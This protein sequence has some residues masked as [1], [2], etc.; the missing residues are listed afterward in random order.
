MA[1]AMAKLCETFGWNRV[2]VVHDNSFW[3]EGAANDFIKVAQSADPSFEAIAISQVNKSDSSGSAMQLV[4]KELVAKGAKIVYLALQRAA[5]REFFTQVFE[6]RDVDD[7]DMYTSLGQPDG[8]VFLSGYVDNV[9]IDPESQMVDYKAAMG[10]NGLIGFYEGALTDNSLHGTYQKHWHKTASKKA[11]PN[12]VEFAKGGNI[13]LGGP[14]CDADGTFSGYTLCAVDQIIAF[15]SSLSVLLS[16]RP[17]FIPTSED[18]YNTILTEYGAGSSKLFGVSGPI[19]FDRNGDRLGIVEIKNFQIEN[20]LTGTA[21]SYRV[22]LYANDRIQ[23]FDKGLNRIGRWVE[24][25]ETSM[26]TTLP[27]TFRVVRNATPFEIDE[28]F[29]SLLFPGDI[30]FKKPPRDRRL[31]VEEGS[32]DLHL[33]TVS[34]TVAPVLLLATL[35][36]IYFYWRM[37]RAWK[38]QSVDFDTTLKD[39]Q[40]QGSFL[41]HEGVSM[42]REIK[43]S[44]VLKTNKIGSGH[45]GEVWKGLLDESTTRHVDAYMVAIK[46]AHVTAGKAAAEELQRE[47]IAMAIVGPHR[48]LVSLVGVVTAGPPI[49]L[50]ISLCEHGSLRKQLHKRAQNSGVLVG[51]NG[52][53]SK[54]NIEIAKEVASGMAALASKGFVHRDLAARHVLVD[55]ALVCKVADFG[56]SR[57]MRLDD[58]GG[59]VYTSGHRIFP[60]RWTAPEAMR[61]L[62]FSTATD[63]WS[64]GVLVLELYEDGRQPY[65]SIPD[66]QLVE[67]LT[68][69]WRAPQPTGCP[70]DV[71][72]SLLECWAANPSVRPAFDSLCRL[73]TK[74]AEKG[75]LGHA[76]GG[77]VAQLQTE[78]ELEPIYCE[79]NAHGSREQGMYSQNGTVQNSQPRYSQDGTSH[80]TSHVTSH[81]TF[82]ERLH[83]PDSDS[84]STSDPRCYSQI[85]TAHTEQ[86][87]YSHDGDAVRSDAAVQRQQPVYSHDGDA[88]RSDAAVQRQPVYA[89]AS[90]PE[91]LVTNAMFSRGSVGGADADKLSLPAAVDINNDATTPVLELGSGS[92][93]ILPTAKSHLKCESFL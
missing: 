34:A 31:A 65:R 4:L 30:S 51:H 8:N 40:S 1:R 89:A 16:T 27:L 29:R 43:R 17:D 66:E 9:A 86:P 54:N 38:L 37:R 5:Q 18:V 26:S 48:H 58:D 57:K 14:Y 72:G 68:S 32:D 91:S 70:R 47:A 77:S 80:G 23:L 2:A 7:L 36:L 87:V 93:V 50:V 21:A 20:S 19:K 84:V 83:V 39:L 55:S 85:G 10:A 15:S 67:K 25:V 44:A 90:S 12:E 22:G 49:L 92:Q 46:C 33:A 74:I 45:S 61:D 78:V 28:G 35:L 3:G 24:R 82:D 73:Y 41:G 88:V 6:N 62:T 63:V 76:Q 56:S 69:G 60:L 75:R 42:P 11:C 79:S 59:T 71:Y 64:F 81:G 52:M 53:V 13:P